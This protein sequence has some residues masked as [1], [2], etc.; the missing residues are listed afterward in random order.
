MEMESTQGIRIWSYKTENHLE[1]HRLLNHLEQLSSIESWL[2]DTDPYIIWLVMSIYCIQQFGQVII[3]PPKAGKPCRR[4]KLFSTNA[5]VR[6]NPMDSWTPA[7]MAWS[8]AS[9]LLKLTACWSREYAFKVTL[10]NTRHAPEMLKTFEHSHRSKRCVCVD[11]H[12]WNH[13][14]MILHIR[15]GTWMFRSFWV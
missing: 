6:A 14:M 13:Q 11:N 4:S 8:S 10:W 12:I 7:W 5:K 3:T 9:Q 2:I 15:C 1:W